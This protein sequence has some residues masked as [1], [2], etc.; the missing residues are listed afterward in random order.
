[1][2]NLIIRNEEIGVKVERKVDVRNKVDAINKWYFNG[3]A[4]R[5]LEN[6]DPQ[7]YQIYRVVFI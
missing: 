7:K 3:K 2:I 1:M 4:N 6:K 5:V